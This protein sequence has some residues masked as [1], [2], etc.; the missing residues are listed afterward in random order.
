MVFVIQRLSLCRTPEQCWYRLGYKFSIWH[1]HSVFP[2]S[3]KLVSWSLVASLWE[4][5][6][7]VS[8]TKCFEV[9]FYCYRSSI[10]ISFYSIESKLKWLCC[11]TLTNCVCILFWLRLSSIDAYLLPDFQEFY[12][13]IE[14]ALYFSHLYFKG[15]VTT[16]L[17]PL[18][19]DHI[20]CLRSSGEVRFNF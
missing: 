5:R 19:H 6:K 14:D 1:I 17:W 20:L 9:E 10:V 16:K 7:P 18:Y 13:L 4:S 15:Y 8:C 12:M 11:Y 2:V 3:S